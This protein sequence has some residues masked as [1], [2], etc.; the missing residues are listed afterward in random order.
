MVHASN[1]AKLMPDM[2][3]LFGIAIA[4]CCSL[5]HPSSGQKEDGQ[6]VCDFTL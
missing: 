1:A 4:C 3:M 2:Q 6:K 5:L